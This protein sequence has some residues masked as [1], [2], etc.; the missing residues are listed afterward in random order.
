MVEENRRDRAI[1]FHHCELTL[2]ILEAKSKGMPVVHMGVR[3][4]VDEMWSATPSCFAVLS[5]VDSGRMK[6]AVAFSGVSRSI[7]I[8]DIALVTAAFL[9]PMYV[10]V[11]R[12]KTTP[13]RT[14]SY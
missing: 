6:G 7:K 10:K 8:V 5:G 1:K 14:W 9:L 11:D 4:D 13:M 2:R 3:I 12:K